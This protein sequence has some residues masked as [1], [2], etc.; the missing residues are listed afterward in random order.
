MR[1]ASG[2]TSNTGTD[3]CAALS[4]VDVFEA[5]PPLRRCG[6][7]PFVAATAWTFATPPWGTPGEC[8]GVF[9]AGPFAGDAFAPDASEEGAIAGDASEDDAACCAGKPETWDRT[10]ALSMLVCGAFSEVSNVCG[11]ELLPGDL[12]STVGRSSFVAFEAGGLSSSDAL[13]KDSERESTGV[14]RAVISFAASVAGF[15]SAGSCTRCEEW[16][17]AGDL[18]STAMRIEPGAPRAGANDEAPASIICVCAGM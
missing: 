4:G 1:A 7:L 6:T 13:A 11:V 12:A 2:A 17:A 8:D 9:V 16:R 18:P 3:D 10:G 5:V 14:G 15:G